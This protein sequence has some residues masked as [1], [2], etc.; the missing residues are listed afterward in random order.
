MAGKY[1]CGSEKS[2]SL[3]R[4]TYNYLEGKLNNCSLFE[5]TLNC[6]VKNIVARKRGCLSCTMIVVT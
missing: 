4:E 3:S 6:K 1:Y 5:T 2:G